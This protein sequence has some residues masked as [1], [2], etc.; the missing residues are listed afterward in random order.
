MKLN[1]DNKS[2]DSLLYMDCFEGKNVMLLLRQQNG[3][4]IDFLM[5]TLSL[6]TLILSL[7]TI[8]YIVVVYVVN[9]MGY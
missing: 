5:L 2:L 8:G 9:S 4:E 1:L 3:K 6:C 7:S